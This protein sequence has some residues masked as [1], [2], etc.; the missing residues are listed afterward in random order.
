MNFLKSVGAPLA[1]GV[2][3]AVGIAPQGCNHEKCSAEN[4]CSYTEELTECSSNADCTEDEYCSFY[5]GQCGA[6]EPG[7]CEPVPQAC[8][9]AMGFCYCD[10]TFSKSGAVGC[11]G[12]MRQDFDA[13]GSCE[14]PDTHFACGYLVC[15]KSTSDYCVIT[16]DE[17][18]DETGAATNP[19]CGDVL[20]ACDPP[21]CACLTD[22]I[23][24]CGGTCEEGPNG[25]TVRCPG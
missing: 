15:D 22:R 20:P 5:D 10:G 14:L 19:S 8:S 11:V 4:K 23:A 6:G 12:Y 24:E 18:Y 3:A 13:T 21:S 1:V 16:S 25:P 7:V 17:G 2:L 9:D